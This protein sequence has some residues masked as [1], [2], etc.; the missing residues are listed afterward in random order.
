VG[1]TIGRLDMF[2]NI[3]TS[4]AITTGFN[5]NQIRSVAS[6]D[7]N[8]FWAAGGT[9]GVQYVGFGNTITTNGIS[10][11][12]PT[13]LRVLN[14]FNGNVYASSGS[15][16]TTSG[17]LQFGSGN[18]TTAAAL[19][20][21]PSFVSN[22]PSAGSFYDYYFADA[23][24]AYVA[25]DSATAGQAGIQKWTLSAGVW[26]RVAVTAG[27]A[28]FRPRQLTGVT[29]AGVTT[30][31]VAGDTAGGVSTFHSF[32]DA[33]GFSTA[34]STAATGNVFRG[35]EIIVPSPASMALMG[36]GG[37]VVARRRRA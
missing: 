34:I 24:T 6:L 11:G 3:D 29:V 20:I 15:G 4:T 27:P 19:S 1:R 21:L 25:D 18:Q 2:G 30:L 8:N 31:Y 33:G 35:I 9:G 22:S 14:T 26:S 28:G 37:L 13:N 12:A 36:L 23:N 10:T 32:T 17:V 16:A 5:G 7:G